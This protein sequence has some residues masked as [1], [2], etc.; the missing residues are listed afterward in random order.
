MAEPSGVVYLVGAGPGD[1]GLLTRRGEALLRSAETV[2]Y[3]RLVDPSLLELC[4]ATTDRLYVGKAAGRHALSQQQINAV[5]VR[6]GR[7]G[8]RVVRLKGGD[9]FVFGRGGEE[10]LALREAGIRFEI[11]PGVTSAVAGPACAGIPVTH[12]GL[13]TS[14]TIVTGHEDPTTPTQT[15]WSRLASAGGTLVILMGVER[16]DD[17]VSRL[18]GA[19]RPPDQ[20]AALIHRATLPEQQTVRATLDT[21]VAEARAHRLEPPAV[22]VVGAV[23]G[24]AEHLS[25]LEWRP[26]T[27]PDRITAPPRSVETPHIDSR[28]PAQETPEVWL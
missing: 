27:E 23:V 14:V 12:R 18:I 6:L 8:R 21:I 15:D 19:G 20:P 24:L 7:A 9:P 16:L 10:A 11:V 17:I 1:P 5:L 4:P 25:W 22:L 2:V 3:D 13:A 28:L 26:A